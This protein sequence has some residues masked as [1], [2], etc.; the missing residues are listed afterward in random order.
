MMK[1][2]VKGSYTVEASLIFPMILFIII[3]FIYLGFYL[4]DQD[5]IEAVIN[6]TLLKSRNLIQN[7]TDI[8]SGIMDYEKYYKRG[9]LYS[10]QNNLQDKKQEIYNYLQTQ[11][12][13][14]LFIADINYIGIEVSHTSI[15]I[16]IKA[17]MELPFWGVQ[18]LF[19]GK[20]QVTGYNSTAV[21][22][23]TEFIRIFDIFSSV[24]EKVPA[25]DKSLK[26][27]QQILDK[28]AGAEVGYAPS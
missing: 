3:G 7:D 12:N 14:G 2:T 28:F 26:K 15:S 19:D 6:E 13:K 23:N 4:H 27:L 20:T 17:E 5:K 18:S 25:I 1:N 11:L 21:Q 16:E 24:A 8:K 22:N 9:I 10:L